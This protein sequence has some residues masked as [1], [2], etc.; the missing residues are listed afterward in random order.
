MSK[1]IA[2]VNHKGGVGKTTTTLNLGKALSLQGKKVLII[3]N[4]PQGNLSQYLGIRESEK[5]M[6]H[7]YCENMPLPIKNISEN[8]DLVPADLSLSIAENKLA[9][10]VN[11]YFKLRKS[12]QVV[13][14]EYDY[15]FIDC[16][17][18]L[19]ILTLNAL[20]AANALMIVVQ[21]QYLAIQGLQTILDLVSNIQEN[22]N[23]DL[24]IL[25]TLI[26]QVHRTTANKTVINYLESYD[27]YKIFNAQ[28]R[29]NTD[30]VESTIANQDI[31]TYNNKSNGASDY[32]ALA[33]ELLLK[34]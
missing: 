28:I 1:I 27:R 20:I 11:A 9:S 14:E 7:I 4:D 3:D 24:F 10:D 6:Y 15:I 17:P 30:F 2:I 5:S 31:F 12:L 21:A 18:S 34:N 33:E 19:N 16:Q 29:Q 23:T 22:L 8:F 13:K 26:T 25:G 32:K